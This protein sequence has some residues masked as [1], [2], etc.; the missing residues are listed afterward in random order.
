MLFRSTEE[1]IKEFLI[2]NKS[3]LR[4]IYSGIIVPFI[5]IIFG[6]SSII[7]QPSGGP[8]GPITQKYELPKVSGKIYYVSIDGKADQSG[9]SINNPTTIES[10]IEKVK[11]GDAIVMRG[12]TYRTGNLILNQGITIQPYK[13]EQPILKGTL[14]AKNW[15]KQENGIWVTNWGHLFPDKAQDWWRRYRHGSDVPQHRFNDDM[16]FADGRFLQS[17]GWEGELDE[18]SYYIDYD[19]KKVYLSINPEEHEIE[20]T[21]HDIGLLRTTEEVHGKKSDGKGPI[22]RGI[23]FTQYATRTIEVLG[24]YPTKLEKDTEHGKDVIGTVLENCTISYSARMGGNFIG[25][26]LVIRNCKVSDTSTEGIYIVASS[27]VLL[28][29]NIFQ[30]NN[31]ENFQGYYPAA[32]KI[33]NQSYRVT[34]RDNLVT[35]Q[36][37]SIGIW[38]DVGNVDG[39]F[40]NNWLENIH[41]DETHRKPNDTYPTGAGFYFEI[42]RGAI[43]AGNVFV[44]CDAG[45]HVRNSADVKMY[46]NTLINSQ[47]LIGRDG[48]TATG[49]HFDWHPSTGPGLTERYGHVFVNNLLYVDENFDRPL[50][51]VYQTD[52]LCKTLNN[53]QLKELDYNVYV[54][55]SDFTVNPL[56]RWSP[57]QNENCVQ[58]FESLENFRNVYPDFSS[59]SSYEYNYSGPLFK[60]KQ[61]GNYQP[62]STFKAVENGIKL[63]ANIKKLLNEKSSKKNYIGAYPPIK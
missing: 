37:N 3:V 11:T 20:I 32:V 12:G 48:R 16:V 39:V 47:V 19:S 36:F 21:A 9:E 18:N 4:I 45:I 35:D 44:N 22:I 23:T 53:A 60:G 34:C 61:L 38:Y 17:A 6:I 13:D 28:E 57:A 1:L 30:R 55:N 40:I 63:N 14:V 24:Y 2:M 52:T 41:Y 51:Y 10:A 46:Q 43:C 58:S 7:A 62:F 59:N 54:S 42:S 25:D 26:S 50:L 8:Y 49:D 31:I 27:D 5:L 15:E 29:K 56:I 33:F